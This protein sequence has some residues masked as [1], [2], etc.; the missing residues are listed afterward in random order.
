[1]VP[2]PVLRDAFRIPWLRENRRPIGFLIGVF[3]VLIALHRLGRRRDF[4]WMS[5][6]YF[7]MTDSFAQYHGAEAKET[8]DRL[9]EIPWFRMRRWDV[10]RLVSAHRHVV[11]LLKEGGPA[12]FAD[13]TR[14]VELRVATTRFVAAMKA[15][16]SFDERDEERVQSLVEDPARLDEAL[17]TLQIAVS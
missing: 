5:R 12:P 7:E 2:Y 11:A 4:L 1:V 13:P 10:L 14:V 15:I 8:V 6:L 17:S 16:I 9:M 3:D